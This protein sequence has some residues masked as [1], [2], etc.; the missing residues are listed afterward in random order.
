MKKIGLN[1]IKTRPHLIAKFPHLFQPGGGFPHFDQIL[2][3]TLDISQ[4]TDICAHHPGHIA[5][6]G[7]LTLQCAT[8][9]VTRYVSIINGKMHEYYYFALCEVVII[10]ALNAGMYKKIKY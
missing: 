7:K 9:V 5:S 3:L 2:D 8:P 6:G 1:A 10:G 4:H